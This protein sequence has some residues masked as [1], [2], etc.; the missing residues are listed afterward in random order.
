MEKLIKS[1]LGQWKII[2]D[3]TLNKGWTPG[4]RTSKYHPI[5]DVHS[6]LSNMMG[7]GLPKAT[8]DSYLKSQQDHITPHSVSLLL[9]SP[10]ERD[11]YSMELEDFEN[12]KPVGKSKFDA[13][14]VLR[15]VFA[16]EHALGR[17]TRGVAHNMDPQSYASAMLGSVLKPNVNSAFHEY[18]EGYKPNPEQRIAVLNKLTDWHKNGN[19]IKEW[20]PDG[21]GV[22]ETPH[23]HVNSV[24]GHTDNTELHDHEGVISATKKLNNAIGPVKPVEERILN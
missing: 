24:L 4:S 15:P 9:S 19:F 14:K 1:K 16:Q 3:D 20:G 12:A 10:K 5:F 7:R 13:T 17:L 6:K 23:D 11:R 8:I 2:E 22:F 21:E 18:M